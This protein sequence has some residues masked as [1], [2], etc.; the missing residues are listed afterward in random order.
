MTEAGGLNPHAP[1]PRRPRAM[2]FR[3]RSTG[4]L[5]TPEQSR[6]QADVVRFAWGHFGEPGPVIAFLNTP[7]SK[8]QGQPLQL[9]IESDEGLQ[10]VELLLRELTLQG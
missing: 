1:N 7:H 8:L 9:A 2:T 10:R 3:K 6:R 4:P 5:P